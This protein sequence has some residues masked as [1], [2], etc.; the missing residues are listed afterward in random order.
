MKHKIDS[1]TMETYITDDLSDTLWIDGLQR[2]VKVR[3]QALPELMLGC[4]KIEV[5]F[6]NEDASRNETDGSEEMIYIF[7]KNNHVVQS[8]SLVF[9][10]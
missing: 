6:K 2:Q 9:Y 10:K 7:R 4:D 8:Y 1:D 3:K 5:E